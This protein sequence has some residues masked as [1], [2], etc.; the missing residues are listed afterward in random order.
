MKEILELIEKRKQ[1]FAQLP[2]FQFLQDRSIDPRK[3]LAWA[4]CVVP[5]VMGFGELNRV[6]LRREPTDDKI[7]QLIN[8]HTHVDD[9]H[10]IWFLEDLEKLGLDH[11]M[12]FSDA[13]RFLWSDSTRKT[14]Q[15]CHQIALHSF[16]AEPI[17]VLAGIEAIEATGNAAFSKM[18]E[19]ANEFRQLTNQECRYFGRYH[20]AVETGHTMGTEE[21]ENFLETIELTPEQQEQ[22]IE[23]VEMVFRVFTDAMNEVLEF[24][25]TQSIE[26]PF[27]TNRLGKV[28][29]LTA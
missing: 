29:A 27:K 4:P 18:S 1:E 3:R 7:Q 16:K 17:V 23:M 21:I 12:K 24:V 11:Q 8:Q 25:K 6:D 28:P 5:L 26:N 15:V 19:V 2:L 9:H 13:M 20:L 22:A 10:W 14:R